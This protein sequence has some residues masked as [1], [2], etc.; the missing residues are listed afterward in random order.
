MPMTG[1]AECIRFRASRTVAFARTL[2]FHR[3]PIHQRLRADDSAIPAVL[4]DVHDQLPVV[5]IRDLE[6][7]GAVFQQQGF[8]IGMPALRGYPPGA[9]SGKAQGCPGND[10]AGEDAEAGAEHLV[11]ALLCNV[12]RPA[13]KNL[14][15]V[16]GID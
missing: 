11:E 12:L 2:K 6:F 10:V 3:N 7:V 15:V 13:V 5:G 14:G 1:S 4:H 8:L 16:D 9:L